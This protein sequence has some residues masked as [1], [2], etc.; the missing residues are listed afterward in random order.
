NASGQG[1]YLDLS[2]FE[3]GFFWAAMRH[4]LDPAVDPRAHLFPVNDVFETADGQ[5]LTLGI[6]EEHFWDNF[7]RIVPGFDGEEFS[8]DARRRANGDA[9]SRQLEQAFLSKTASE[10]VSLLEANDIPVDLCVTPAQAARGNAQLI[11]REASTQGFATFPVFA[12]GRRGGELR[13]GVPRLGEQ[14]REIL[15]ELGF[16]DA[17][18][19]QFVQS[20]TVRMT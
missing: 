15:V 18:I 3:A 5:R 19:A 2:L 12:G 17:E 4:G 8:S 10:W 13:T 16:D 9:L 11:E 6:L 7:R 1:R 14:S 20:G